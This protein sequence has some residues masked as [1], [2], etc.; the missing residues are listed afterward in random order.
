MQFHLNG[1]F[2][3]LELRSNIVN[4]LFTTAK[5]AD[6]YRCFLFFAWDDIMAMMAKNKKLEKVYQ[7]N[8]KF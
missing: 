3:L 5:T 8:R 2:L 1:I 7:N 6:M 4:I